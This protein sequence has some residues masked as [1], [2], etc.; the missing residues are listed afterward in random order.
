MNAKLK[1][2]GFTGAALF[3]AAMLLTPTTAVA[4]QKKGQDYPD[5]KC[6]RNNKDGTMTIGQCSNVCKD[7]DVSTTKDVDTGYRTCKQARTVGQWNLVAVTGNPS[8]LFLRYNDEGEVQGCTM[9][10]KRNE[11]ECRDLT[12]REAKGNSKQVSQNPKP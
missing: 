10:S 8:M 2:F 3:C 1:L 11:I 5:E 12:I 4:D 9:T 7:L 6:Q